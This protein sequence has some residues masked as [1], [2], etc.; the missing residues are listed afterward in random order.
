MSPTPKPNP[1]PLIR[2][3][4]IA[5]LFGCSTA[6]VWRRVADKTLPAPVRFGGLTRWPASEIQAVI[7]A[8]KAQRD[9]TPAGEG[10]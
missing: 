5:T 2:D 7:E 6:T 9:A 10:V 8:A 4:D 1:D 3:E